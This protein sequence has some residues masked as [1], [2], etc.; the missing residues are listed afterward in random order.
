MIDNIDIG[1]HLLSLNLFREM[2]GT[3]EI[4]IS[5]ASAMAVH[6]FKQQEIGKYSNAVDYYESLIIEAANRIQERKSKK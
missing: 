1:V 5:S 2:D 6:N 3:V 4:T